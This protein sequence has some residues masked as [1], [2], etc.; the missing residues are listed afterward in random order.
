MASP[1]EEIKKEIASCAD[2]N[3]N[4]SE[5]T[6]EAA[7]TFQAQKFDLAAA[8]GFL[9]ASKTKTPPLDAAT[10]VAQKI[11][12][13]QSGLIEH[14]EA[15]APG[16]LNIKLAPEA[17]RQIQ[18]Q[19]LSEQSGYPQNLKPGSA[20]SILLE[21][22]SANPTGPLHFGH[23]R[24]AVLGDTLSR[25]LSR[26]GVAVTKEYYINDLGK[27]IE[28]LGESL[29]ARFHQERL[30]QKDFPFPEDGY[31]GDY[32]QTM[33]REIPIEEGKGW[34]KAQF[35]D[36]AKSKNLKT[37]EE[38]LSHLKIEFSRW[39]P[40]S[41]LHAQGKVQATLETLKQ[42]GLVEEKEGALW[43]VTEELK[44]KDKERV[45]RKADGS[46]T[47]F[48]SDL[49]YH[50]DKYARE[51]DL[52]I[53]V[54]GA[55]HHGYIP[56]LRAGIK[57]LGYDAAKLEFVLV[58]MVR[59]KKDGQFLTLSKREGEYLTMREVIEEVGVDAIRFFLNSRTP[60]AQLDFDLDLAKKHTAENPVY[61]IQYA[62][63]RVASIKKEKEARSVHW[64]VAFSLPENDP[65]TRALIVQL[66]LLPGVL[67]NCA[68]HLATHHLTNYLLDLARLFNGY[69]ETHYV[70]SEKDPALA[71]AR[72]NL[73]LAAQQVIANGLSI[74]GISAPDQM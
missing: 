65:K 63:A 9:L 49:A 66:G 43:L 42:K 16:F 17:L 52:L 57:A 26:C 22:C 72:Y 60:N 25:I 5:I 56:R 51:P 39:F 71:L 64:D 10:K 41:A 61:L 2:G 67:N 18:D 19:V 24:G 11:T 74:L 36:F 40:E 46:T 30:G 44:E 59:L 7:P 6:L 31:H 68:K 55:D 21:F 62:H 70:L 34:T 14:C 73:C 15:R 8:I 50:Q 4:P 20:R 13:S 29:K 35:S 32:L 53:N 37:I 1:I 33:A 47:Y 28:R 54:L 27:Q 45:L 48:A 3:L 38:D 23:A 12:A 69:Y 58:Q